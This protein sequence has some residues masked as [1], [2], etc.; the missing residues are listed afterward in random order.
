MNPGEVD[1]AGLL[2]EVSDTVARICELLDECDG[3]GYDTYDTRVGP[4]YLYLLRT[5]G[6]SRVSGLLLRFLYALEL[7][8]PIAYRR[9]RGIPPTWD[10]MGNSYRAGIQLSLYQVD[11]DRRRLEAARD[12]LDRIEKCAVGEAPSR[13]FA[14]GFPCITGSNMLWSTSTPVAHYSVRV[15]RKFLIWER[16]VGDGRYNG[17]LSEVVSFLTQ[18]LP[19]VTREAC[20][21]V[22]YTPDDPLQVINIWADVASFLSSYGLHYGAGQYR[23]RCL[24]LMESV[25]HHQA[26]D[27]SWPYFAAWEGKPGGEDNSHTAM[28]LGGLADICA[29]YPK[30]TREV[31][32]PALERGAKRWIE[33]FFDPAS[34]RHWNLVNRPN[35]VSTV[36]LGDTLYAIH[37]L[38]RPEVGLDDT[39]RNFLQGLADKVVLWSLRNLR[40]KN[41]RFCERSLPFRKYSVRS[42]RSFDG[43]VGDSLA[44]YLAER[45]AGA[46]AILWT[47]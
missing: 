4:L 37:R 1:R 10:P 26:P 2:S 45:N 17:A 24:K 19:W 41:G 22:A 21:G 32:L 23:Q 43:L 44:L 9:I 5:R 42:V 38:L 16:V 36:C 39:L 8:S 31:L 20:L 30:D 12:I 46:G 40:L 14:L 27:G 15:A 6:Q 3:Y 7:I 11:K 35:Q 33:M 18:V 29:C 47:V 25:L 28:V 13:G 34:G